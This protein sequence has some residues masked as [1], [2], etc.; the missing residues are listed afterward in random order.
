M[1]RQ[2][3]LL[4]LLVTLDIVFGV[5]VI[6]DDCAA[7]DAED[8]LGLQQLPMLALRIALL[9]TFCPSGVGIDRLR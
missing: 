3:R 2:L 4:A 5:T 1:L 9:M 8:V 6:A 7:N